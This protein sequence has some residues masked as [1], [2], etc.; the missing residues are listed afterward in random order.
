MGKENHYGDKWPLGLKLASPK[1]APRLKVPKNVHKNVR[2][3][4][5]KNNAHLLQ[6]FSKTRINQIHQN[7][8]Y[9]E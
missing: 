6:T 3:V 1:R 2:N 9:Q 4:F 7:N 5:H 8:S